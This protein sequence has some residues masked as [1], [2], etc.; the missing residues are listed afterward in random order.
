MRIDA[1]ITSAFSLKSRSE[2]QRLIK[3]GRIK[4][5]G[6]TVTRPSSEVTDGACITLDMPEEYYASRAAYKIKAGAEAFGIDFR[7]KAALDI[8]ASTGGFTDFMLKNGAEKVI[9]LDVGEGQLA[10]YLRDD[11]RV[12][13]MEKYNARDISP[14]DLPYIPDIVTMDVSF[15]SATYIIENVFSVLRDGGEFLCLIKPQ[16]E[17]GKNNIGKG[18]IVKDPDAREQAVRRVTDFA[19]SRG[20]LLRGVT[21][22]PIA[23]GDGNL[24]YIAYFL[25]KVD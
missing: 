19:S 15:I 1:Y 9:A 10:A 7:G 3:D 25:K 18:G 11:P 5:S 24:E 16:F 21:E 13:V 14:N 20:F 22:S 12:F 8:G 4:I 23:G 17:V 6:K 2:A